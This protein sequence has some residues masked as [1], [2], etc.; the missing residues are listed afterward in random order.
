MSDTIASRLQ[1]LGHKLPEAAGPGASYTPALR[2]G[3][4]AFLSGQV[5]RGTKGRLG[6]DVSV[7]QGQAAA[8]EVALSLFAQI[9]K[10][11]DGDISKLR[12]VGSAPRLHRGDPLISRSIPRVGNGA[13][14]LH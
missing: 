11:V 9:D 8:V 3:P 13:S 7:E 1:H 14:D 4:L 2:F 6:A 12:Q 10:L 5:S